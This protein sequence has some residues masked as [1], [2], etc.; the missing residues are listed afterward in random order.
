MPLKPLTTDTFFCYKHYEPRAPAD[1]WYRVA[2][3]RDDYAGY[4]RT[5]FMKT[6]GHFGLDNHY[7]EREY[8]NDPSSPMLLKS[9][10]PY[11]GTDY[12]RSMIQNTDTI[13]ADRYN[14]DPGNGYRC[15]VKFDWVTRTWTRLDDS[16][17]RLYPVDVTSPSPSEGMDIDPNLNSCSLGVCLADPRFL[18]SITSREH[19][20]FNHSGNYPEFPKLGYIW[21]FRGETI[22]SI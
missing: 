2:L 3:T 4:E 20:S 13:H 7:F 15:Q 21:L 8:P 12:F 14:V 5:S 17:Y 6:G 18:V 11:G 22:K 1:G 9:S 10:G 16:G 19:Y